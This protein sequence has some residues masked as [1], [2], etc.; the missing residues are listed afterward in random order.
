MPDEN[1]NT[2]SNGDLIKDGLKTAAVVVATAATGGLGGLLMGTAVM[3][4]G[5]LGGKEARD[6]VDTATNLFEVGEKFNRD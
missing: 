4:A 1:D 5:V 6:A 2:Y 3:T